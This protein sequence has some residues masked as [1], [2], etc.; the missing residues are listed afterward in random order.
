[1][2]G[3]RCDNPQPNAE[4]IAAV[5]QYWQNGAATDARPPGEAPDET[6]V[7]DAPARS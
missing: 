1:M 2:A 4:E 5:E 6:G 7:L 3:G